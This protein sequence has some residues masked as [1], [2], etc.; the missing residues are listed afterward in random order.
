MIASVDFENIFKIAELC[1]LNNNTMLNNF[2]NGIG[3]YYKIELIIWHNFRDV[4]TV[5]KM[6]NLLIP[7][8]E[9]AYFA[10]KIG[11]G[12]FIMYDKWCFSNLGCQYYGSLG[13]DVTM[14]DQ[15]S[16]EKTKLYFKL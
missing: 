2:D 15:R 5:E 11:P 16:F 12:Y 9:K 6:H 8:I 14:K 4:N 10:G 1:S 7:Y 13:K 3:V